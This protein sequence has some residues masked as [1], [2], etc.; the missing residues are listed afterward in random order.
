MTTMLVL[1]VASVLYS[2]WVM[3]GRLLVRSDVDPL[4]DEVDAVHGRLIDGISRLGWDLDM[5]QRFGIAAAT[6]PL[7]HLTR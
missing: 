7:G 4:S 3:P 1:S 6:S 2:V 5:G